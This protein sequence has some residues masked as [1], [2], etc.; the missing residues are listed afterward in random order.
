M[1]NQ[2][3]E[4]WYTSSPAVGALP[5]RP[6]RSKAKSKAGTPARI[7]L[8]DFAAGAAT[9]RANGKRIAQQVRHCANVV[10]FDLAASANSPFLLLLQ[11]S[12]CFPVI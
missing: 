4:D 5:V 2:T 3:T 8:F 1:L 12:R 7:A 10:W 9:L 6:E 11:L